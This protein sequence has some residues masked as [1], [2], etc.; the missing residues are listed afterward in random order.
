MTNAVK[1]GLIAFANSILA[2]LPL[3]GVPLSDVQIAALALI[4]NSG[5]SLAV[6]LTYKNSPARIPEYGE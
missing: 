5:L 4:V 3:F 2:A 6:L 1:A